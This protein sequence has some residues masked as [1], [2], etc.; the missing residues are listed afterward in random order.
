MARP[1]TYVDDDLEECC[2]E[3]SA[4]IQTEGAFEQDKADLCHVPEEPGGDGEELAKRRV[5]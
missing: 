3:Y 1:C 4:C 2:H 5:A